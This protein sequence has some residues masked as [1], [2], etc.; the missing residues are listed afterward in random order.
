MIMLWPASTRPPGSSHRRRCHQ[1]LPLLPRLAWPSSHNPSATVCRD[2]NDRWRLVAVSSRLL[3]IAGV[4]R[5]GAAPAA[6]RRRRAEQQRGRRRRR[7]D[8]PPPQPGPH[9]RRRL[10][11]AG[12]ARRRLAQPLRLDLAHGLAQ[13]FH[14]PLARLQPAPLLLR[15][16]RHLSR[17]RSRQ[18]RLACRLR[19]P[20]GPPSRRPLATKGRASTRSRAPESR[21]AGSP[22]ERRRGSI[23]QTMYSQVRSSFIGC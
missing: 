9:P 8:E 20:G 18:A 15:G 12:R 14:L 1:C 16:A 21:A 4:D 19:A 23:L 3:Y 17:L 6:G 10:R 11:R 2:R 13:L 7:G 5:R 22:N